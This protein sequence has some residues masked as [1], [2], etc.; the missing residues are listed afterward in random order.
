[1]VSK[2]QIINFFKTKPVRLFLFF[3]IIA[4]IMTGVSFAIMALVK[5]MGP[6]CPKGQT[7]IEG[8]DG[9]FNESC[10]NKKCSVEGIGIDYSN[11]PNC[12]CN[13]HCPEGFANVYDT[14]LGKHACEKACGKSGIVRSPDDICVYNEPLANAAKTKINYDNTETLVNKNNPNINI[15][16]LDDQT[17]WADGPDGKFPIIC[18]S[19]SECATTKI[20]GKDE[21]YCNV[22]YTPGASCGDTKQIGCENI[23]KNCPGG[24]NCDSIDSN[25]SGVGYCASKQVNT[26]V[27][28]AEDKLTI[29]SNGNIGCCDT[30]KLPVNLKTIDYNNYTAPSGCCPENQLT[31][32][33]TTCCDSPSSR[34]G[35][36][37]CSVENQINVSG[38]TLCCEG[39]NT[40]IVDKAYMKGGTSEKICTEYD[41]NAY[42][43][44]SAYN[45][46]KNSSDCYTVYKNKNGDLPDFNYIYYNPKI[47]KCML[48]CNKLIS[49]DTFSPANSLLDAENKGNP[50][51]Y[52]KKCNPAAPIEYDVIDNNYIFKDNKDNSGTEYW[53]VPPGGQAK[54]FTRVKQ[55]K[56]TNPTNSTCAQELSNPGNPGCVEILGDNYDSITYN[57]DGQNNCSGTI[58][59]VDFKQKICDIDGN[60]STDDQSWSNNILPH[61]K[62]VSAECTASSSSSKCIGCGKYAPIWQNTEWITDTHSNPDC[63]NASACFY[64]Q[65]GKYCEYGSFDGQYCLT[66]EQAQG[67][68]TKAAATYCKAYSGTTGLNSNIK[69][70]QPSDQDDSQFIPKFECTNSPNSIGFVAECTG[71]G[72]LSQ[73]NDSNYTTTCKGA[74]TLDSTKKECIAANGDY[75]LDL[76]TSLAD[77]VGIITPYEGN[78]VKILT[79]PPQEP[80]WSNYSPQV[81]MSSILLLTTSITVS[82]SSSVK[83]LNAIVDSGTTGT[84]VL[85][86]ALTDSSAKL[87]MFYGLQNNWGTSPDYYQ[88]ELTGLAAAL[89]GIITTNTDTSTSSSIPNK[90][91]RFYNNIPTGNNYLNS[92]V[93][94]DN[95]LVTGAKSQRNFNSIFPIVLDEDDGTHPIILGASSANVDLMNGLY[96]INSNTKGR[97]FFG[98]LAS[99]NTTIEFVQY[100]DFKTDEEV[101]NLGTLA[102]KTTWTRSGTNKIPILNF[103]ALPSNGG[104][105]SYETV[106]KIKNVLNTYTIDDIISNYKTTGD[107]IQPVPS[108]A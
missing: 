76:S 49:K 9:C 108:P 13:K 47:K 14:M 96:L 26:G 3:I 89:C 64:L 62:I 40:L 95:S 106:D 60:L 59:A 24:G 15:C 21:P 65:N 52:M 90:A 94:C 20:N 93:Y 11:S 55:I 51:C 2:Q 74:F 84:G 7:T 16:F 102:N 54:N 22:T 18:S 17:K 67:D 42:F 98:S 10:V 37:C 58:N 105:Q 38:T 71:N 6:K 23:G 92:L 72:V 91:I 39:Q 34:L 27:C 50:S 53:K 35:N 70:I 69:C 25:K 79:K 75:L 82:G 45:N 43:S 101:P 36:S 83:Y 97:V 81:D 32:D 31:T 88:T 104:L 46:A 63:S 86:L 87:N 12:P 107:L 99:D 29:N 77:I 56:V 1:M 8:Q 100:Y 61:T 80:N 41:V 57:T 73:I 28:C 78:K 48:S 85:K 19:K 44:D 5:A 30:G 68:T 103:S 4:G 33:K 66:K